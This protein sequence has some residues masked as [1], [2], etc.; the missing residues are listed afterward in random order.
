MGRWAGGAP[1]HARR[2]TYTHTHKHTHTTHRTLTARCGLREVPRAARG[3]PRRWCPSRPWSSWWRPRW[4]P[5]PRRS[6]VAHSPSIVTACATTVRVRRLVAPASTA[7]GRPTA[8]VAPSPETRFACT[9]VR[10]RCGDIPAVTREYFT[11]GIDRQCAR[12]LRHRR[13]AHSDPFILS[14]PHIRQTS[15]HD[16]ACQSAGDPMPLVSRLCRQLFL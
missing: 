8:Y 6:T 7:N 15:R 14:R 12:A 13:H 11:T 5:Q 9:A 10:A 4:W 2:L 3:A 1:T 16:S